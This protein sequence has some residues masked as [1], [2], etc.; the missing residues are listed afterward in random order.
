MLVCSKCAVTV[1]VLLVWLTGTQAF[2][3]PADSRNS[4]PKNQTTQTVELRWGSDIEQ[5]LEQGR[6]KKKRILVFFFEKGSR[7]SNYYQNELFA[8]PRVRQLLSKDFVLVRVDMGKE[9]NTAFQLGVY[10]AG[11]MVIY[12]STGKPLLKF[13]QRMT[14]EEFLDQVKEK[15]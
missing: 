7:V 14:A 6:S 11:T 15:S 2:S 9:A 5:A 8:D 1:L 12:S 4:K 3:R 13:W 10:R